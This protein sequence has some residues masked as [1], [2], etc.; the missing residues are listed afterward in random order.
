MAC[1][2][3]VRLAVEGQGYGGG[4]AHS[5]AQTSSLFHALMLSEKSGCATACTDR[6]WLLAA[7]GQCRCFGL[8]PEHSET[9]YYPIADAIMIIDSE[10]QVLDAVVSETQ[11]SLMRVPNRSSRR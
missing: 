11:E 7:L 6:R 4:S 1:I 10:E 3:R 5:L 2:R 8:D 9:Y